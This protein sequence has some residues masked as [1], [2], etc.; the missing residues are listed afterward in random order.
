[1]KNKILDILYASMESNVSG[2]AIC[3]ELGVSRTAVWKNVK[4]LVAQ[5]YDIE[6]FGG[7]GYT[8][9]GKTDVLNKYEI[10]RRNKFH[11]SVIYKEVVDSTNMLA[12]NIAIETIEE[13]TMVAAGKQT[14]GRGRLGRD[15]ESDNKKGVWCSFI[16]KPRMVPEK[17]LLITIAAAI[18]VC[19]TLLEICG[20]KTG[21]KWP[22]DIIA[23]GKKIC[24]ILSEMSC[25]TGAIEYII[26]GIGINVLQ[27]KE[28]FSPEIEKTATS[29]FM[30]TGREYRRSEIISALCY[31]M[32][33]AY[34]MVKNGNYETI[35]KNWKK[36]SATD[37]KTIR[38]I[39][40]GKTII[41][42]AVGIDEKGRLVTINNNGE[43]E[44]YNSG[45]ISVRGIMGYI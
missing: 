9:H 43:K 28:E 40:N 7:K 8:L 35:M 13:F 34:K 42:Q 36:Y 30:E 20:I 6:S 19:K 39:K 32:Q 44:S 5:G 4:M 38:I 3:R 14:R 16:M 23:N 2:Q 41:V 33:E 10:D 21:I 31:N 45:E 1:M 15:F 12:R 24:G 27:K 11:V 29:V 26:T 37:G 17:A 22:N 18:A 25:E